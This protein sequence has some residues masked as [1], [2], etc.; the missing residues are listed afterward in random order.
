M[1]LHRKVVVLAS[2]LICFSGKSAFP[3]KTSVVLSSKQDIVEYRNYVAEKAYDEVQ[4]SWTVRLTR[5]G[6]LVGVFA[7]N[8]TVYE[9]C[10]I[11]MGLFQLLGRADK[12]LIVGMWTGG[13]KCCNVYWIA[14]FLPEMRL[15][16]DGR[17]NHLRDSGDGGLQ[18][19]DLDDDGQI[20][21]WQSTTTFDYFKSSFADSP[22]VTIYFK[23]DKNKQVYCPANA[24]LWPV[25]ASQIEPL[26]IDVQRLNAQIDASQCGSEEESESLHRQNYRRSVL[27]V[28]LAEIYAG[29][30]KEAW[31][32]FEEQYKPRDKAE[33]RAAVEKKL[34]EEYQFYRKLNP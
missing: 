15:V 29:R 19:A 24:A 28:T 20:E 14:E 23:Y 27:S 4:R 18:A 26:V 34:K 30:E 9:K 33:W 21:F 11:S 8:D 32:F 1:P 25:I 2:L 5:S 12:Q 31:A 10:H 3:Q 6:K 13:T 17:E 7:A 22:S 16:Y